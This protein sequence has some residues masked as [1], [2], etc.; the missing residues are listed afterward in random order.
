MLDQAIKLNPQNISALEMKGRILAADKKYKEAIKVFNDVESIN[1][2]AGIVLKVNTYTAMGDSAK[3][4]EQARKAIAKY[5][6]SA[7]G[8]LL[9]GSVYESQKDYNSAIREVNN[10][11]RADGN[12]V[13]ALLYLGKLWELNKGYDKAMAAY[14]NALRK[15]PDFVPA[16]YAQGALLDLTGKKKEAADKYKLCI[17]KSSTYV[18][19]L[20][21]LAYLGASGYGNKDEALRLAILAFK[22]E[23]GNVAV[24]DTL[25][26][27]LLKNRR[28]ADAKKVLEKTVNLSQSNPTFNYHL[29][30]AYK[31]SG[32]K[33]NAVSYLQK[34]L[35]L[36]TFA[37]ANEAKVMLAELRK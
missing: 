3:A 14:A 2:D 30:L 11:L 20:N 7:R 16:I 9:L 34:A 15:K 8:Y 33:Q 12:D 32:D 25:G 21:N 22:L 6:N 35:S 26:Y 19:A 1:S 4:L 10:G 37:E 27:V 5:P 31:E 29:A 28:I 17:E 24:M 18:P 36:G 13:N 23:P